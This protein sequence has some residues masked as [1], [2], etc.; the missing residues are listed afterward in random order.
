MVGQMG[1]SSAGAW[2]FGAIG[3]VAGPMGTIAGVAFGSFLG[4]T[5]GQTVGCALGGYVGDTVTK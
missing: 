1:G 4:R 5:Y 3:S 2:I